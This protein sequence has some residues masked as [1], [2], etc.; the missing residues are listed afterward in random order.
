MPHLPRKRIL[1]TGGSSY[2]G[3]HLVPLAAQEHEIVYTY[4]RNDPLALASGRKVDVREKTAVLSLISTFQ[5]HTIIHTA[6]SNR[7]DDVDGVIRL[8]AQHVTEAAMAV[9]TRLIH[10]STDVI[11]DGLEPLYGETAVCTPITP[12]GRAKAA[13]ESIVAQHDNHAIVRTSLIYSLTQMDHGTRWMAEALR[14]G[15]PVTLFNNQFRNPVWVQTLCLACLELVD[16]GHVG[17]L[18]VAGRQAMSRAEFALK[19]LDYWRIAERETITI[20][21]ST[22][23]KWPLDCCF[24]LGLGT[25]VLNIP[26]LGVD[27]VLNNKSGRR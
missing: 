20:A 17:I 25:A 2:L 16:N 12:Y 18:N 7:G 19:M 14:A 6:G 15:E 11:F 23:N 24:D 4:F 5:P 13:A 27:D 21:P 10:L 22:G 3:Q 9:G 26:L 1:I 8:G